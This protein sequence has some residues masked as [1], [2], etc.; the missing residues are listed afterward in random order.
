MKIE[1][2]EYNSHKKPLNIPENTVHIAAVS[3]NQTPLDWAQNSQNILNAIAE[4]RQR[5][6]KLICFP[7]LCISGYGCE[8]AFLSLETAK[9]AWQILEKIVPVTK[10]LAVALGLPVWYQDHLYNAICFVSDAKIQGFVAKQN[11]AGYGVHYEP[12]WFKPWPAGK[13]VEVEQKYSR[14]P[15]RDPSNVNSNV[16]VYPFG[17]QVFEWN[18]IKIGFEICEDAWVTERIGIALAKRGVDLILNP[19]AS[20]FAFGKSIVRKNFVLEATANFGV[21]Y[22]Y[23]NLLGNEAGRIIYDGDTLIAAEEQL[24]ASGPRFSFKD[25]I[26]TSAHINISAL[27]LYRSTLK[28]RTKVKMKTQI[29]AKLDTRSGIKIEKT[30]SLFE[31]GPDWE[32]SPY[33]KEEEFTRAVSLAL[34]DYLRK[35]KAKGFVLNLSGG[36]DSGACACLV[37]FLTKLGIQNLGASEFQNKLA[38]IPAIAKLSVVEKNEASGSSKSVESNKNNGSHESSQNN[39]SDDFSKII[40]N[41]ILFCLSQGTVNNSPE[42]K[43][44]AKALSQTLGASFAEIEID[45]LVEN[46]CELISG[47][48]KRKLNWETD[49]VPLQNIQARVRAPSIWL[50]ANLREALVICPSNRS[51]AALGYAT[52]DGDTAGGICPIA[53]IDKYFLLQWLKWLAE[54]GPIGLGS[55]PIV[56]K[57]IAISPSAELRPLEKKQ[58]DEDDLMPFDWLDKIER[59]F[60]HDKLSA[61]EILRSLIEKMP[62]ESPRRLAEAVERFIKLWCIKQWKRERLAPSFHLDDESVDPKTWCRFPIFSGGYQR[63]LAEMWATLRLGS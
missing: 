16:N 42:T 20:H 2:P 21:G 23:A 47:V 34:F 41:N 54:I 8:D 32:N 53:G 62:Q 36:A 17:D 19:S 11:L 52:M 33:I 7:E 10:D 51:E 48:I 38:F 61:A 60:V 35:S 28:I 57:I 56:A 55:I 25:Y 13:V 24:L 14:D 3:L 58:K 45:S 9:M 39:Q 26:L 37:Y 27:R 6:I 59:L 49:D 44:I 30:R 18:G 15:S 4:A 5:E 63:E 29:E 46:Y 40:M 50:L 22:I 1:T 12:R 43:N 31:Q